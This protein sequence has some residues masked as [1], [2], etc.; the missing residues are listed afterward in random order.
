MFGVRQSLGRGNGILRVAGIPALVPGAVESEAEPDRIDFLSHYACSPLCCASA[1]FG[2]A[3]VLALAG[4]FCSSSRSRTT[5]VIWLNGFRIL[6]PRPRARAWKCRITR[7]LPTLASAT[8]RRSKSSWRSEENTS[9]LQ[10]PM[11]ISYARFCLKHK[12]DQNI[13]H[14]AYDTIKRIRI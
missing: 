2:F 13:R 14:R 10:S 1:F 7:P 9:E 3:A 8:T 4:A 6:A 12:N 11:R 5:M